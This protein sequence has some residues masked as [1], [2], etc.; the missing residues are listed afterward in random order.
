MKFLVAVYSNNR[1]FVYD[2]DTGSTIDTSIE[3]VN[4]NDVLNVE[5]HNGEIEY[6]YGCKYG[7]RDTSRNIKQLLGQNFVMREVYTNKLI[8]YEVVCARLLNN[9]TVIWES[10][11]VSIKEAV[12]LH[13]K[14]QFKN[15]KLVNDGKIDRLIPKYDTFEKVSLSES[16]RES[17]I[18]NY[19][20]FV[21]NTNKKLDSIE[22]S[23]ND[24]ATS[25]KVSYI[26]KRLNKGVKSKGIV[27]AIAILMSTAAIGTAAI[28]APSMLNIA[29]KP[30][31]VTM[32]TGKDTPKDAY[33]T[34][35]RLYKADKVMYQDGKI[36]VDNNYVGYVSHDK[37]DTMQLYD[38][39]D[40]I[41]KEFKDGKEI[42]YTGLKGKSPNVECKYTLM[43][44]AT[45]ESVD[46]LNVT[47]NKITY[48]GEVE[49]KVENKNGIVSI[50][51]V[52][53]KEKHIDMVEAVTLILN[54]RDRN[55]E[56]E[57]DNLKAE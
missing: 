50:S 32:N 20:E 26:K 33:S 25:E 39:N 34:A 46:G 30:A 15:V 41:I 52:G 13:D 43:G 53:D 16:T 5:I 40:N 51:A 55:A 9:N 19:N 7:L 44:S 2:T 42:D 10:R 28:K 6:K 56:I 3:K 45:L 49:Y 12:K 57:I 36:Y 24:R 29:D 11:M 35:V 31:V 14:Y 4:W 27:A 38:S 48:D 18:V 37:L 1:Q 22:R 23:A 17:K 54:V 47:S 21:S 8:G